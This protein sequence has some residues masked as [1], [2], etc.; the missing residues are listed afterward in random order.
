[1]LRSAA[2]A[3]TFELTDH[4]VDVQNELRTR[5]APPFTSSLPDA[6]WA[7]LKV[8]V[9]AVAELGEHTVVNVA[10]TAALAD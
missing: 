8:G 9:D 4:A 1:M 6:S 2:R 7:Q 10:V 3:G 5:A